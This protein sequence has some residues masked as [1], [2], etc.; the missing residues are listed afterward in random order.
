MGCQFYVFDPLPQD[1]ILKTSETKLSGAGA[2]EK[3][4]SKNIY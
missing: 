1:F 4:E 2:D 3:Q